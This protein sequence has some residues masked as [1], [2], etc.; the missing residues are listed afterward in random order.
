MSVS[1]RKVVLQ[2]ESNLTFILLSLADHVLNL[3]LG[4]KTALFTFEGMRGRVVGNG[5][6]VGFSSGLVKG[7]QV[8]NTV[9]VDFEGDFDLSNA[10]TR[11][12]WDP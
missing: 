3:L 2:C 9:C 6:E 4:T 12:W 11:R 10:T 1:K 5:D 8:E 7:G